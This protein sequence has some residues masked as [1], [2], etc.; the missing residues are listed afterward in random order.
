MK[1][2]MPQEN[3]LSKKEGN[4]KYILINNAKLWAGIY[5]TLT[6]YGMEKKSLFSLTQAILLM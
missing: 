1:S 2:Y 5:I 4:G 6:H 3:E